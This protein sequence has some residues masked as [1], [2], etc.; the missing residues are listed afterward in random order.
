MQATGICSGDFVVDLGDAMIKSE[1]LRFY[2]SFRSFRPDYLSILFD[3]VSTSISEGQE[4][5]R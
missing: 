1:N 3:K 5:H 4:D 2:I